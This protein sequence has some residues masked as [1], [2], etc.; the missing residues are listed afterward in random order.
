MKKFYYIHGYNGEGVLKAKHLSEVLGVEVVPLC[1]NSKA[2]FET[3]LKSL[4]GNF[5]KEDESIKVI[6][7]SS[8]GAYYALALTEEIDNCFLRLFNPCLDPKN[9][10]LKFGC[11]EKIASSYR[12]GNEFFRLFDLKIFLSIDDEILPNNIKNIEKFLND[13]KIITID[14]KHQIDN[15]TKY[16]DEILHFKRTDTKIANDESLSKRL[17]S[18]NSHLMELEAKILK[19]I[20]IDLEA[21]KN[22]CDIQNSYLS[23]VIYYFD[24]NN[25]LIFDDK[26]DYLPAIDN[27]NYEVS[28]STNKLN[29]KKFKHLDYPMKD[30]ENCFFYSNLRHSLYYYDIFRIY[31]FKSSIE[32]KINITSEELNLKRL[33]INELTYLDKCSY[34]DAQEVIKINNSLKKLQNILIEKALFY[35]NE[36]NKK[37]QRGLICAYDIYFTLSFYIDERDPCYKKDI[38]N[39]IA[40]AREP[41]NMTNDI[42]RPEFMNK[43]FKKHNTVLIRTNYKQ[44]LKNI[45]ICYLFSLLENY[46]NIAYANDTLNQM[47][48]IGRIDLDIDY[49]QYLS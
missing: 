30:Q 40:I 3:N 36:L 16:K 20:E 37:L 12:V 32:T 9:E 31:H 7:A 4:L 45:H 11:E 42:K 29:C 5:N 17:L 25:K 8:L 49:T 15:F 21:L 10:L 18:L 14:D 35:E 27:I 13:Y 26:Y 39:L 6:I 44:Y 28:N 19:I 38:D 23:F 34:E 2:D 1:Y 43:W 41:L 47:S 46:T 48:R 33:N 24:R 22:C